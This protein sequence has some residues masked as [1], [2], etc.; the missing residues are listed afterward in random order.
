M[1]S[2]FSPWCSKSSCTAMPMGAP[3]RHK[4]TM[5]VGLYPLASTRCASSNESASNE[6]AEMNNLSIMV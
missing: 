1:W 3:P 4:A 6:S 5:N 2:V